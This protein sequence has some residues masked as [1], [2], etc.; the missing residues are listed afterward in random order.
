MK[1]ILIFAVLFCLLS[2]AYSQ[3]NHRKM[4]VPGRTWNMMSAKSEFLYSPEGYKTA[5]VWDSTFT[6]FVIPKDA[7]DNPLPDFVREEGQKVYQNWGEG[8]VLVFDFGLNVGDNYMGLQIVAV[9]TI[10]VKGRKYRRL[11]F[12]LRTGDEDESLRKAKEYC[13]VEGIGCSIYGPCNGIY[14]PQL[15]SG[16]VDEIVLS[17][18]DGDELIFEEDDFMVPAVTAIKTVTRDESEKNAFYDL[19]GRRLTTK[20]QRGLYIRNG[21][22]HVVR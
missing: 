11:S 5:I 17:V 14:P 20:P 9:D 12:G 21:K 10:E 1:R 19:Q 16:P 13:W 6:S 8:W 2:M 15:A 22:K 3:N 7:G 4:F 18:Y